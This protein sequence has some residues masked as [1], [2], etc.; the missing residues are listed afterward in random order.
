MAESANTRTDAKRQTMSPIPGELISPIGA[1]PLDLPAV[2]IPDLVAALIERA[3]PALRRLPVEAAEVV[4][5]PP[6]RD[7]GLGAA[8]NSQS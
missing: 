3:G 1:Q 8:W 6:P 4:R 2:V 5:T 7:L